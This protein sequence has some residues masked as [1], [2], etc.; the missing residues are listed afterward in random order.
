LDNFRCQLD[1]SLTD[2]KAFVIN[3]ALTTDDIQMTTGDSG[4]HE[5]TLQ[6][7]RFLETTEAATLA[8]FFPF[9]HG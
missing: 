5:L 1:T 9:S 7:D 3:P 8:C 2:I 6:I 4:C